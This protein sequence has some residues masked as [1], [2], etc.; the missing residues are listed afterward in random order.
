MSHLPFTLLAY[1]LNS[2]SVL[3]D[4]Y[5]LSKQAPNPLFY[6]YYISLFS[7]VGLLPLPWTKIPPLDAFLYAS[8]STLLWT[9][10]AYFMF[11]ALQKGNPARVIPAIGTIIPVVLTLIA[12]FN[13]S[14]T[15]NQAW[16]VFLLIIGL[17]FLIFPYLFGRVSRNEA[18]FI[19]VSALLF[20]DSYIVLRSS[21]LLHDFLSIFVYSRVILIPFLI[22]IPII[23]RLKKLIL[24]SNSLHKGPGFFSKAG[25]LFFLGQAA[26]GA[27]Q[28][29][30]TFS[31]SLANPA[32]VNSLQGI[33]YI[34]LFVFGLF[35]GKKYPHIFGEKM[36]KLTLLSKIIGIIIIA[37]GLFL[38]SMAEQSPQKSK[39]YTIGVNYAPR[40][41]QQLGLDPLP[42]FKRALE[43]LNIKHVRLA[44]YWDEFETV[45]GVFNKDYMLD[46]LNLAAIN[47]TKVV[48]V[49]GYKLPR[50]PECY[51]PE[52]ARGLPKE[53]VQ[54]KL[55]RNIE[56]AIKFYSPHPSIVAWQ[57]ENEPF[58]PFGFCPGEFPLDFDFVK[59]EIELVQ[60]LDHRPILITDS[61]EISNWTQA[62]K[63]TGNEADKSPVF[64][65]T[66]LYRQVWNPH[67]GH[68]T[69][70]I[71]PLF[72]RVK[73]YIVKKITKRS[74]TETIISELQVEP[75]IPG[76]K[77]MLEW[78][79]KEQV[80]SFPPRRIPEHLKYAK[81]TGF[82]T[83]Y[84]WGIE[85]WYFME[86]NG[87]PE[88]KEE[89]KKIFENK[90]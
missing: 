17:I 63:L 73:D 13:G 87:Q 80:A 18:I 81:D 12:Y 32:L 57:V 20:A 27:S 34:F 43:E 89:A 15:P 54:A 29:L 39:Q 44:I 40:F 14:I 30:L 56:T 74:D 50:W 68:F 24:S 25:L 52:W 19:L 42:T 28:L 90:N 4:K 75:W 49:V 41:A 5:L 83:I 62:M 38:L 86:K 64:F 3:I 21:Y 60:S 46:Y 33:Q 76:Q 61:G 7:L 70:P 82:T 67:F 47:D 51:P 9:T 6:I 16:S 8:A 69:Y 65:G 71:P 37:A 77:S 2:V 84:L 59:K 11:K 58:L 26:G 78:D 72:Y 35:L 45:D 31:I 66:T 53:E 48:L 36:S 1:I 55:L 88:Y 79:V 23:P 22:T 10:G 85:W